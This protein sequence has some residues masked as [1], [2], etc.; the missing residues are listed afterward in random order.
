M[1]KSVKVVWF[2]DR[3][4][5]EIAFMD[6]LRYYIGKHDRNGGKRRL[7][8]ALN[9][10]EKTPV[11][12]ACLPSRLLSFSQVQKLIDDSPPSKINTCMGT[13]SN[14]VNRVSEV[15]IPP[16]VNQSPELSALYLFARELIFKDVKIE[17]HGIS[18]SEALKKALA[19][20]SCHLAFIAVSVSI[21]AK[22]GIDSMWGG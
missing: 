8:C 19:V 7:S 17:Y 14:L 4:H 10:A 22:Q 16:I 9:R 2:P 12:V 18:K 20:G 5:S 3:C 1:F 6:S 21:I 11:V 13:V 15:K